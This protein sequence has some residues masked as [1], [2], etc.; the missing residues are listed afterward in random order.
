M[1]INLAEVATVLGSA[2]ATPL[3][4][5]VAR[6]W[7]ARF[8]RTLDDWTQLVGNVLKQY[9]SAKGIDTQN[10]MQPANPAKE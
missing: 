8:P 5:A 3:V 4:T 2:A 6:E 7:P 9:L 10:P 1:A